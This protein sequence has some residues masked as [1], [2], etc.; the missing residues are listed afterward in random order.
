MWRIC[1]CG[2]E[3]WAWLLGFEKI[4][5]ALLVASRSIEEGIQGIFFDK[6]WFMEG[7]S[8]APTR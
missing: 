3:R 1:F 4:S 8:Q 6:L 7:I 2:G 5:K